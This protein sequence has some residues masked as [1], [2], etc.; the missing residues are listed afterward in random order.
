MKH[1]GY[2]NLIFIS[3]LAINVMVPTFLCLFLGLFLDKRFDTWFT[4]PLLFLGMAAGLRN[5]YVT[6][7]AS[8]DEEE[9]LRKKQEEEEIKDILARY[10]KD[11]GSNVQGSDKE[12]WK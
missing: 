10:G 12:V 2:K 11:A 1:N 5:V 6:A 4:V 7:K 3:Q 9:N 8:I